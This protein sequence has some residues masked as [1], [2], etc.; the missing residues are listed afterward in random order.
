MNTVRRRERERESKTQTTLFKNNTQS[1]HCVCSMNT[2]IKSSS[3]WQKYWQYFNA[4]LW[5][6]TLTPKYIPYAI[7]F[8]R[9]PGFCTEPAFLRT[10]L[11][12]CLRTRPHRSVP[13]DPVLGFLSWSADVELVS[14]HILNLK[15]FP[16]MDRWIAVIQ[17]EGSCQS[18]SDQSYWS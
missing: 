2:F 15:N 7:S 10:G 5:A 9:P 11:R 16:T 12:T 14:Q 13:A 8:R 1:V 18:S 3:D 6:P 4:H 17:C